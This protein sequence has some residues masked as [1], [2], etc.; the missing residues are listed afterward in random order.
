MLG[1]PHSPV[2]PPSLFARKCG[3]TRS[4]SHCLIHLFFQPLPC[5][6]SSL[7]WPPV[8]V[9][10]T[11]LDECF[12]FNSLVV[13]LLYSWIFW[14]FWLFFVFKFV[15]VLLLVVR[16]GTVYLPMP[17]YWTTA[18]M[19][20]SSGDTVRG[21]VG[22]HSCLLAAPAIY[23]FIYLIFYEMSHTFTFLSVI[24]QNFKHM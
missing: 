24:W 21:P 15:V 12:F 11:G 7:P 6:T 8:S 23:L 1:L 19:Q 17:P 20:E 14:H 5:H 22:M 10:P 2:V 18:V 16:G 9:P 13:G 4:A 3:T